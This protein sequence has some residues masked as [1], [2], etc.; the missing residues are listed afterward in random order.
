MWLTCDK[1]HKLCSAQP[2]KSPTP[3][4]VTLNMHENVIYPLNFDRNCGGL[5]DKQIQIR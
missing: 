3:S 5:D 4:S 2:A 1:V